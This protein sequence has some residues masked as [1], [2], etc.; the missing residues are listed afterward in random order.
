MRVHYLPLTMHRLA[1]YTITLLHRHTQKSL[2][3]TDNCTLQ[4]HKAS[5]N[6]NGVDPVRA[7]YST[8]IPTIGWFP[9]LQYRSLHNTHTTRNL[10]IHTDNCTLQLL[11]WSRPSGS[12][13]VPRTN[14]RMVSYPTQLCHCTKHYCNKKPLHTTTASTQL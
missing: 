9:T 8:S 4:L 13:L 10:M 14:H 2:I 11:Q 5:V 12:V 6:L 1:S 7:H 3:H